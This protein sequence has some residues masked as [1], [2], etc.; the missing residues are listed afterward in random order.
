M[1]LIEENRM[2]N[3]RH[4]R[5]QRWLEEGAYRIAT[6]LVHVVAQLRGVVCGQTLY[7]EESHLHSVMYSHVKLYM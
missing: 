5:T 1:C 6:V 3:G 2:S 7:N 4:E